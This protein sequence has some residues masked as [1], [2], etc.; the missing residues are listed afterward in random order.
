M[1]PLPEETIKNLEAHLARTL[2]RVSPPNEIVQR[3]QERIH[4]PHVDEIRSRLR[5][6]NKLFFIFGGVMSG[7]LV[8]ITLARMLFY[9]TGRKNIS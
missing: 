4:F 6:W 1:K 5:D 9:F 2:R 3:L 8:I 7:L